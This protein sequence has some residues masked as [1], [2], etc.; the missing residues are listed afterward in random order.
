MGYTVLSSDFWVNCGIMIL[1]PGAFLTLGCL[2]AFFHWI[3]SK[4]QEN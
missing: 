2:M 3:G 4:N 1:P